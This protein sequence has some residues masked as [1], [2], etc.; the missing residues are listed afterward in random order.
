MNE[1]SPSAFR[2]PAL[3]L[4]HG[5]GPFPLLD[6]EQESYRALVR[7]HGAKLDGVEGILLFSA[8]WETDE[9]Q[10]TASTE[11]GIFY[12][13][14]DKRDQLP[15]AAFE[16]QYPAKGNESLAKAVAERLSK[17]G[18]APVLDYERG[19]DHAVYVP[20][21]LLR[22]SADIPIV[23]MSVL[24]SRDEREATVRN[25]RL[26]EAVECFRDRGYAIIGSGGSYHDFESI[27]RAFF[28]KQPIVPGPQQDFED[29]LQ[30]TAAISDPFKRRG[31]LADWRTRPSSHSAH[32]D[33]SSEHLIPFMV[34]AGSGG[35]SSGKR[36]DVFEFRGAPMSFYQW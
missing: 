26:G 22:P 27:A 7:K 34:V 23:Q 4:S 16:F 31:V 30:V 32:L 17:C 10:I 35:S 6:P 29:F 5:T 3:F 1:M 9:P 36:I 11:P 2:A 28:T 12:D 33:R 14:E 18:F 24:K 20:M 25:I 8:H 21:T 19:F 15:A 13:Y